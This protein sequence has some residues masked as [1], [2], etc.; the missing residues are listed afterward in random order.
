VGRC[1]LDDF[2]PKFT[3][4][5]AICDLEGRQLKTTENKSGFLRRRFPRQ[6]IRVE[7]RSEVE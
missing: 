1:G 3:L 7:N 5:L 4:D 6:N 2:I